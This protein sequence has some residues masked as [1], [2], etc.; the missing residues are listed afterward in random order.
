MRQVVMSTTTPVPIRSGNHPPSATFTRFEARNAKSITRK[1]P[2]TAA[3]RSRLQFQ[4][5]RITM[6]ARM[7]VI[8]MVP[9]TATP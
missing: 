4:R 3:A 9:V 1:T 8:T 6:N 5:R 7:V 2:A